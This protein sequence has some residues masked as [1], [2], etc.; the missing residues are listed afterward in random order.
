MLRKNNDITDPKLQ[1]AG[2]QKARQW[3]NPW[4]TCP[5][6]KTCDMDGVYVPAR[7]NR[8]NDDDD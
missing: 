4:S 8:S 2:Y 7:N 3:V 6:F 5:A 1:S